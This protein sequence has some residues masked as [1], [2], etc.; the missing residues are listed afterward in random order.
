MAETTDIPEGMQ[1]ELL[2]AE[3]VLGVLDPHARRGVEARLPGD[4]ALAAAVAMWNQRLGALALDV[5]DATPP[6]WLWARIVDALPLSAAAPPSRTRSGPAPAGF[7]DSLA[8]WR[9]LAGGALAAAVIAFVAPWRPAPEIE[10]PVAV[11]PAPAAVPAHAAAL[12]Q[13]DGRGGYT[14]TLDHD[15]RLRVS[16]AADPPHSDTQVPELWLIPEGQAPISLGVI[17]QDTTTEL[18]L[19]SDVV[20]LLSAPTVLAVTWEPP[21]GAPQGVA[22]GPVVAVGALFDL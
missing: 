15:H 13:D 6:A 5:P 17:A 22:T 1:T 2:A 18:T 11:A 21:G 10:P 20:P 14:A 16:P 3:Y 4:A 9:T 7:W 19:P 8:F 12:V